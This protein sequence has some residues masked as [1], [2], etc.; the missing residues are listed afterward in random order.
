M[1]HAR[2]ILKSYI[3]WW[4][5]IPKTPTDVATAK[6]LRRMASKLTR[7]AS[8]HRTKAATGTPNKQ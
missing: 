1:S 5:K 4:L 6:A 2:D 3:E 7:T 8:K